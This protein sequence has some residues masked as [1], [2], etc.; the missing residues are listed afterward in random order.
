MAE[1]LGDAW[2]SHNVD[3]YAAPDAVPHDLLND[4]SVWL[5]SAHGMARTLGDLIDETQHDVDIKHLASAMYG[6]ATLIEMGRKCSRHA[7]ALLLLEAAQLLAEE[8]SKRGDE[9]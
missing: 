5:D 9:P 4:A 1:Q 8:K 2:L 7:Q 3:Y 6:I